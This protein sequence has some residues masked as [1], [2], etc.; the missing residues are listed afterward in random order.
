MKRIVILGA[1][2][3]FANH[4][5]KHFLDIGYEKVVAV[6]RNPR[7]P[8]CHTL[9]IGDNDHRYEYHQIHIVFEQR[10]LFRLF[11]K[12]KPDIVMNYAALAYANSWTDS[13]L[14]YKTN[15]VAVVQICEYLKQTNYLNK[16]IQIG[17]S[18]MYGP[19][20]DKPAKEEDIPNPT[21]PYAVSKLAADMHLN[22][23]Y[24]VEGFPMNIVRPSNCY[25]PGQ[26]VYRIIPKAI[27]YLLSNKPFPLEGG[28]TAEKSFMYIDDLNSAVQLIVENDVLGET[29]NVGPEDALSMKKIVFEICKQL[30]KSTDEYIKMVDGRIGE[31][32]KY[33]IESAKIKEQ[34]DWEQKVSF[35]DG[36]SQMIAW[37]KEYKEELK[38]S[39]DLFTLRA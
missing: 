15:L 18:E 20:L 31:D 21:S 23:L 30:G 29:F 8:R 12:I 13:D 33:W 35:E 25:G 1:G 28:G 17:T 37:V 2:G 27:L 9:G 14:F 7:L 3:V 16:F 39:P 24:S 32:R 11:E 10:R 36:I 4:M 5:A 26:Y 38:T 22:T 19:T 6:G 34:L